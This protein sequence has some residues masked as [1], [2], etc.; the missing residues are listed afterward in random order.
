MPV[1]LL[2]TVQGVELYQHSRELPH[3]VYTT[4]KLDQTCGKPVNLKM[5]LER[6]MK[7]QM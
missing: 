6:V 1:S 5:A 2:Q 7:T 3:S 4:L